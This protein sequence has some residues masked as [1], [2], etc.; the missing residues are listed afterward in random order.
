MASS[1]FKDLRFKFYNFW[2]SLIFIFSKFGANIDLN[3]LELY[4]YSK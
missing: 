1:N 4:N 3:L 2:Q